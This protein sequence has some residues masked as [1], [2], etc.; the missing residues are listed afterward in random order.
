MGFEPIHAIDRRKIVR[1]KNVFS[2]QL[3]FRGYV[4]FRPSTRPVALW[5]VL[6]RGFTVMTFE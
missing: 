6:T 1:R 4:T 2:R 3:S 5:E